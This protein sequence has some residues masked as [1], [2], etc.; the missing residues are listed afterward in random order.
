M[1][2]CFGMVY[3]THEQGGTRA[4]GRL[5]PILLTERSV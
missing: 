4:G 5:A 3:D 1:M 2:A